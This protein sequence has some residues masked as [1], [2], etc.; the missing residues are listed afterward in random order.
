M[1]YTLWQE[2]FDM[3][4]NNM[5]EKIVSDIVNGL[6]TERIA[7][8]T[9]RDSEYKNF[10]REQQKI[11]KEYRKFELSDE[12]RDIM[13]KY[14]NTMYENDI[15]YGHCAYKTRFLDCLVIFK[16]LEFIG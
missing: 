8:E 4:I 15:T 13:D 12:E 16:Q 1:V 3:A 14:R 6:I 11:E 2:K 10:V 5:K 7:K 9:E